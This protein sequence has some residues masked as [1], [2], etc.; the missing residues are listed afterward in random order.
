MFIVSDIF[1]APWG[2]LQRQSRPYE[3]DDEN[4]EREQVNHVDVSKRAYDTQQRKQGQHLQHQ[5]LRET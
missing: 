2:T 1:Q 3:D 5:A 4:K